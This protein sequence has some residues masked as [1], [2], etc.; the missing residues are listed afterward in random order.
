MSAHSDLIG[1]ILSAYPVC[2][3]IIK[4]GIGDKHLL[5]IEHAGIFL[6]FRDVAVSK[7]PETDSLFLD[8]PGNKENFIFSCLKIAFLNALRMDVMFAVLKIKNSIEQL[9]LRQSLIIQHHKGNPPI[10]SS[11]FYFAHI[12]SV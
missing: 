5:Y 8:I 2:L 11:V 10:G 3:V 9:D 1:L 6:H 7:L 12:G 4:V